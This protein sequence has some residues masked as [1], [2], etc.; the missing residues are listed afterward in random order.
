MKYHQFSPDEVLRQLGTCRNGL[1]DQEVVA[2]RVQYGYNEIPEAGKQHWTLIFLKQFKSLLVF[3]L[4][5]AAAISW[6]TGHEADMYVILA[7]III[8]ASIGFAQ[9]MRA[10]NAVALLKTMLVPQ[11]KALRNGE[12]V[13]LPARELVPG[14]IIVVEEGDSIPADARLIEA[15]NLRTIEASLTGESVPVQKTVASLPADTPMADC[16]N[17]LYKGTFVAGGYALAVVT[18]TGVNTAIGEI[19]LSLSTIKPTKTN[20]QQKTD[21]LAQQMAVLAVVNA[22]LL[23][24]IAYFY[25][26]GSLDEVLLVAIAAMVSSIPAGLPAVLAIVLA[27]GANRMA[28]RNA[29][30][31]EF[32]A[33]ETLGA[34]TTIITDKTG[35]LTQNTLTVRKVFVPN[36]PEWDIT[37]EGWSPVG[38]FMHDETIIDPKEIPTLS[39]LLTICG[40][41]N[42]SD[43]QHNKEKDTYRLVG[44]PTEGALLALA[45]K[46]GFFPKQDTSISKIDDLPFNSNLKMRATLV[47]T[48]GQRQLLVVGAPEKVLAK[49]AYIAT[50]EGVLPMT[51]EWAHQ[52]KHRMDEWSLQAMRVIALAWRNEPD[53]TTHIAEQHL[54]DLIFAGI[55]G[56]IDPPRPDVRNAVAA[57][58]R[59]GIRVIMATG[60]HIN[61]AIAIARATGIIDTTEQHQ[62]LALTEQQLL[63]LDEKEFE[64]VVHTTNV[65]ARLTPAMKLRIAEKLQAGG[66]LIAMT[67]DG[68]ND[69]PALKRADVGVA[70]GVM[71]TDVARDAA[72][73]VLADDNFSTIVS[74]VEEGRIVFTNA[75]Q[76]SFYLLTT[77]F[78]EIITLIISILSGLPIPLTAT[79]ILW[80]NLV[81]DGVGDISLAT[82]RGHGDILS[83]K[84]INPK[85]NILTS[86]AIPFLIINAGLMTT[87]TLVAFSWFLPA[88]IDK[89]RSGAFIVMAF[90][91]LYNVYNMRSLQLSIFQIGLFTNRYINVATIFSIL[92]QVAIIEIPLLA[93]MF[94]FQPIS[95]MEFITLVGAASG[96]LW[97]GELYK[98]IRYRLF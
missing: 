72:K 4:F 40:W 19:A 50:P 23:F 69:A 52:L 7:V 38:N 78:A 3:V 67:G 17:M 9:E 65:F 58:K 16:R 30:V 73:V 59:A 81:T 54:S 8:N 1:S 18:G 53:N 43:I 35:T 44:D 39:Q 86:E 62:T 91:Q 10:E 36:M 42:N 94:H 92:V 24:S 96:V 12:K 57:C 80:L 13:T 68:V 41:S 56:M 26:Q 28:K 22:G 33:T 76:T 85:E 32:T 51:D 63:T 45:R 20:F 98:L 25:R 5:G 88:G 49:S 55:V 21:A 34:V 70:M 83:Q 27:I 29:I 14:D 93:Q 2:R 74:A 11:A 46:G 82:E 48:K 77:N 71:G 15:K 89:A 61:T 75:R 66:E 87:L 95:F 6:A 37:G 97:M 31:R 60:D 84:P 47:S 79:Q 64:Q 90:C